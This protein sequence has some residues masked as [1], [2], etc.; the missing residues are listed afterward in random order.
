D[1]CTTQCSPRPCEII[2]LT[3]FSGVSAALG[4][5]VYFTIKNRCFPHH[6]NKLIKKDQEKVVDFIEIESIGR[7]G[8][9]CRC[10]KS[11]KFPLCDGTHNAHNTETGDNVGPLIIEA[12]K[13]A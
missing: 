10:W 4:Y 7:K 1:E 3:I 9:Y 6:I 12:K 8:V 13:N 11:K 5:S 2:G